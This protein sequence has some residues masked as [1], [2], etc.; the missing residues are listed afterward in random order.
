MLSPKIFL[1]TL[2]FS[3]F[4]AI[5]FV[6]YAQTSSCT[7]GECVK[8][9]DKENKSLLELKQEENNYIEY[10]T[11]F[12]TVAIPFF[13]VVWWII[14][15]EQEK[16]IIK[17]S[18]I[19]DKKFEELLQEILSKQEKDIASIGL[20]IKELLIKIENMNNI[21]QKD[22]LDDLRIL[23]AQEQKF[24]KI[25]IDITTLKKIDTELYKKI[26]EIDK[27]LIYICKKYDK[28]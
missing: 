13:G 10:L 3:I 12:I 18:Q 6:V 9:A 14:N 19:E 25:N 15:S 24:C 22:K 8:I 17:F 20:E 28:V 2:I 7:S 26:K 16:K 4:F 11:L 21:V 1:R 23:Y 27:R 5:S